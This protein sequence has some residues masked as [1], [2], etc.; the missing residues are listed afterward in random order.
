MYAMHEPP[1]KPHDMGGL[2]AGEVESAEKEHVLWEKRVDAMMMLLQ[3]PSRA[4]L[5]TDELR[6][7]IEALGPEAYT[8][9]SYYERWISAIAA[10]LLER[11]VITSEELGRGIEAVTAREAVLP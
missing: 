6:K 10:T 8:K 7:N 11:G 1:T 5:T 3:H 9:M 4:L 2:P